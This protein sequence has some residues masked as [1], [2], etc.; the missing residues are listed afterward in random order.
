MTEESPPAVR[1]RHVLAAVD[2]GPTGETVARRALELARDHGARLTLLHVTANL[3]E[4]PAYEFM[5]TLPVDVDIQKEVVAQAER[6]LADLG[7]RLGDDQ[8]RRLVEVDTP[9]HG[10]LAAA[11]REEADLIVLG[12]HGVHGLEL[13]LGST[14]NGV[15]HHAP[16]DILAIKVES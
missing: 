9:K 15:L 4:E 7:R 8:I 10:I 16:C 1:Y 3:I 6:T 11:R 12:N 14:A 5:S 13:L 2:L